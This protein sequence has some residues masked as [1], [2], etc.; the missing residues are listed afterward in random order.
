MKGIYGL[1]I[2]I[3]LGVVAAIF[4]WAYLNE[5]SKH[6]EMIYFIGVAKDQKIA[7]G[8]KFTAEKLVKIGLPKIRAKSLKDFT[9]PWDSLITVVGQRSSRLIPSGELVLNQD[10][11][12]PPSTLA[13]PEADR[14]WIPVDSRAIVT[15]QVSAGDFV[16]FLVSTPTVAAPPNDFSGGADTG[17][18]SMQPAVVV[19][20]T[21]TIGPFLVLSLGN[22]LG[23]PETARKRNV[24]R[25]PENVVAIKVTLDAS[26]NLDKKTQALLDALQSSSLRQL[27]VVL[28]GKKSE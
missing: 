27:G 15:E 20:R 24:S 26:G 6:A 3:G 16:S 14:I 25:A 11:K 18:D 7:R 8:E 10:L 9:L 5:K 21:R 23:S 13:V 1:I 28:H 4:N 19:G 17:P 2:A 22:R 12:T